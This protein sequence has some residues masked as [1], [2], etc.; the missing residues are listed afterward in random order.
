MQRPDA[1]AFDEV[2]IY[3]KPRYKES[4]LSGDEW[5]ISAVVELLRKGKV[6]VEQHYRDVES[7]AKFLPYLMAKSVD[8]GNGWFA[9]VDELCDQ[10]GCDIQATTFYRLKKR[11]CVGGGNCGQEI[12]TFGKDYRRQF[13]DIH[14]TRGDC[15]LEDADGNYEEITNVE[16]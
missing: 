7:A 9:S 13:C 14:K 3:T 10:E 15:G 16:K 11:F 12:E 6:I 5:R 1:Q 2:R 4:G 8:D